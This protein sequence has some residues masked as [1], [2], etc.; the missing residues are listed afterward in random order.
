MLDDAT[1]EEVLGRLSDTHERL[2]QGIWRSVIQAA[3]VSLL[4][5][6]RKGGGWVRIEVSSLVA[7]PEDPAAVARL[8]RELLIRNRTLIEARF[9]LADDGDVV[10]ESVLDVDSPREALLAAVDAIEAAAQAHVPAL[11]RL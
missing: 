5:F 8:H 7:I 11:K 1:I 2:E 4:L 10:L 6:V 3:G 9:A